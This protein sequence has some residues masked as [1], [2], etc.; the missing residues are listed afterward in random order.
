MNFQDLYS[1]I[2]TRYNYIEYN[3]DKFYLNKDEGAQTV[4]ITY[5]GKI[6]YEFHFYHSKPQSNQLV[7][8]F[9]LKVQKMSSWILSKADVVRIEV[10]EYSHVNW[11]GCSKDFTNLQE[12]LDYVLPKPDDSIKLQIESEL[13]KSGFRYDDIKLDIITGRYIVLGDILTLSENEGNEEIKYLYKYMS[14]DTFVSMLGNNTFRMNTIVSQNDTSETFVLDN[15][16]FEGLEE[17]NEYNRLIADQRKVLISSF[18]QSKDDPVMWRLY[19]DNSRGV[20]VEFENLQNLDIKH[21]K[22]V[23]QI[24]ELPMI[25]DFAQKMKN[26]GIRFYFDQIDKIKYYVKSSNF[27]YEKELRLVYECDENKL[28][29]TKYG[30]TICVYRDF[31]Y[32]KTCKCYKDIQLKPVSVLLGHNLPDFKT[33]Y[34]LLVSMVYSKLGISDIEM[35][36]FSEIRG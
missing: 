4:T 5:N 20:C 22:Y 18:C 12:C 33:N 25:K 28:E 15:M 19:G 10:D 29:Y 1:C 13:K 23:D 6:L 31:E 14:L 30:N 26:N 36:G 35:S 27:K 17:E 24:R 34:P 21:I 16:L 2:S 9:P 32:D 8:I 11:S 3:R 7:A